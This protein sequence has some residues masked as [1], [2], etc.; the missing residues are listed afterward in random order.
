MVTY[1]NVI[2]QAPVMKRD[3]SKSYSLC[4]VEDHQLLALSRRVG[5]PARR[6]E[7][8]GLPIPAEANLYCQPAG[9]MVE[10]R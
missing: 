5:Y 2:S 10:V 6:T 9:P 4:D 3:D 7:K 1:A 8:D